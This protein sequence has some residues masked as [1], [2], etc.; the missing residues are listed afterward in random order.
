MRKTPL[1]GL[2]ALTLAGGT[3]LSGSPAQA[4][5]ASTLYVAQGSAACSDTGPG[6]QEQPYCTI[7][8]AAGVVAAG[9][10]VEVAG[11]LYRERVTIGSSGTSGQPITFRGQNV[12]LYG[13]TAGITVDGQHDVRILGFQAV[14][15]SAA[16]ALDLRDSSAVTVDGMRFNMPG[17]ATVP[18]VRLSAVAASS[19]TKLSVYGSPLVNGI[20]L[21][22]TTSGVTLT[23]ST[24]GGSSNYDKTPDSF[25]IRVAGARNTIVNNTVA[26]FSDA[27]VE[28]EPG[29]TGTVVA[30]NAI[31]GGA[32]YGIRNRA[33]TG[34][35]ITNNTV[36]ARCR[37]GIRVEGAS[38]G[39]SVQNNV[40]RYNGV[41]WSNSCHYASQQGTEVAVHD[42]AVT[43]TVVDY[44]NTIH[45][46]LPSKDYSW[47]GVL[48]D[49]ATLRTRTGQGAH[50]RSGFYPPGGD[51]D[52]ANSAAPGYQATDR[53]GT[54]RVD[55]PDV[56]NTGAGPI[57]YADRG[58]TELLRLSTA[59]FSTTLDLGV[60]SVTVDASGSTRGSYPIASYRFD[61][62]DGTVVTQASPVATHRYA[63][64]GD[65]RIYLTVVPTAGPTS[66]YSRYVS[67]L[68]RIS[69]VSLLS[70]ANLRYVQPT[71]AGA[72]ASR[73][74]VDSTD[75][76]D[77]A[78]AGN[79]Q[80]AILSQKNRRYLRTDDITMWL[81]SSSVRAEE[82]F[83]ISTNADGTIS[84]RYAATGRYVSV[85]NSG[86]LYPN[87]TTIGIAEKFYRVGV[88][89]ANSWFKAK[90][91]SRYV[92]APYAGQSW[93]I[94][95]RST[96]STAER[97]DLVNLG[98]GRWAL[99]S[100]ANNHFVTAESAGAKPLIAA[101]TT[102][103]L[104]ERFTVVHN[105][106]GTVSLRAAA[107]N[108]YVSADSAGAKSLI[109]NRTAVGLW[110]KFTLG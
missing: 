80:V 68:R 87:K 35:A 19:L 5:E 24:V 22:A 36:G 10:T 8:A 90:V 7:G 62:G 89:D 1:A 94:A 11:G 54:P 60:R 6:T 98:G 86:G 91:N 42:E 14:S 15:V 103:G 109:A 74:G 30:N 45:G 85:A 93:L 37:D 44:N 84:L 18:A 39:V 61:F 41:T 76:F 33:G 59:V 73:F 64:V 28:I 52:S 12:Q 4:A 56:A 34:T 38:A 78:D 77:I 83:T 13:A 31:S 50:D 26:G 20:A 105:S 21:D 88:N 97:F 99:F 107:N 3:L 43:D 66:S 58:A 101:R 65:Y 106:D 29:A 55:D 40:L 63:T 79:G 108:R 25:G 9:Q 81:D 32:G 75:K 46:S 100:R 110:E 92:T 51:A 71:W 57:T 96:V 95:N 23:G 16:P 48:M 72:D 27:A 49:L 17:G 104:W 70:A 47:G 2:A 102:V 53:R 67:V 69:T 82:R